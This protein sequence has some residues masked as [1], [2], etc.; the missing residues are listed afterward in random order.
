[1]SAIVISLD[2]NDIGNIMLGSE[3][4]VPLRYHQYDNLQEVVIK[5]DTCGSSVEEKGEES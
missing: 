1:M 5:L 2:A 4:S 3:L